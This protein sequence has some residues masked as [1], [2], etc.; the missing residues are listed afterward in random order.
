MTIDVAADLRR[1]AVYA[2]DL[3][4]DANQARP[5]PGGRRPVRRPGQP[6][7]TPSPLRKGPGRWSKPHDAHV[8]AVHPTKMRQLLD[9]GIKPRVGHR[10]AVRPSQQGADTPHPLGLYTCQH[11]PR[12][13][14]AKPCTEFPPSHR[15]PPG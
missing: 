11:W 1:L 2:A 6:G 8:A 10:T 13:R 4:L 7:N 14:A 15:H 3:Q 12:R 9:E 5:E